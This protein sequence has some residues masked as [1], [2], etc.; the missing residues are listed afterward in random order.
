MWEKATDIELLG[1]VHSAEEWL[2]F[3]S[4]LVDAGESAAAA[5]FYRSLYQFAKDNDNTLLQEQCIVGL[6]DIIIPPAS[7][8][9][10]NKGVAADPN[11]RQRMTWK[12]NPDVDI[13]DFKL[14][15]NEIIR[16]IQNVDYKALKDRK[17]WFVFQRVFEELE[18]L[19]NKKDNMF[20]CWVGYYFYWP[21]DRDRPWR[22]VEKEIRDTN[23]WQW[24]EHTVPD[25]N[26]GKY[27][28]ELAEIVW[29]TFTDKPK[30]SEKDIPVDKQIF[31][32]P[33][34]K[35]INNGKL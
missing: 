4:K 7:T 22:T 19:F 3:A 2:T 1:L 11:N 26:I 27:Y 18:W 30:R 21:W 29:S 14:D 5:M 16:A 24:N 34:L 13:F 33:N 20:A 23:S 35:K 32:L 12:R 10:Y 17:F 25:T 8:Y 31:Y 15:E 9:K 28:A 6:N